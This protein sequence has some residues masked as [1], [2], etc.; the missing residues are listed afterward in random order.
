VR[1]RLYTQMQD[2]DDEAVVCWSVADGAELWRYR[3]PAKFTGEYA[4]G[5]R[6]TPAIDG[7]HIYT[8]GATGV[9]HCLKTHP[10]G[11]GGEGVWKKDLLGEFGA[12][13][14][15]WGVSFS[16]L[17]VGDLVYTNPGGPSGYS[18]VAL[19]KHTGSVR[20][21]NLDDVAGYSSPVAATIAGR[22]Q[23]V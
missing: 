1:D 11:S 21:H 15:R 12:K 23:I 7:E 18:L 9:M 10:K 20:W 22:K 19:D 6:S 8:V 5:P 14:L 4:F 16:P 17:V 2:G 3:Y 13:N